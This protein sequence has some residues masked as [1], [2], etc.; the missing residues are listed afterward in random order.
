[1]AVR[2]GSGSSRCSSSRCGS[3]LD[4][5]CCSLIC[6]QM[7]NVNVLNVKKD[8]LMNAKLLIL[9]SDWVKQSPSAIKILWLYTRIS[10]T[11]QV[12]NHSWI[13]IQLA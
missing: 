9:I 1:M 5:V 4:E 2:C 12:H 13:S 11:F 3:L 6:L 7:I 8:S 10:F